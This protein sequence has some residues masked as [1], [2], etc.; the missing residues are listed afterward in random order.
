MA[1]EVGGMS[2]ERLCTVCNGRQM[3][4]VQGPNA[5]HPCEHC[6]GTGIEPAA[7][8]TDEGK[9]QIG[10]RQAG[11][12]SNGCVIWREYNSGGFYGASRDL[13]PAL[14][15]AIRYPLEEQRDAF[16]EVRLDLDRE[17]KALHEK[18]IHEV[19]LRAAAEERIRELEAI[20]FH[21]DG[22]MHIAT[23][24]IETLEDEVE[25]LREALRTILD[26]TRVG[27]SSY[28]IGVIAH[29]AL[30]TPPSSTEGTE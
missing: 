24:R 7:P 17:K 10:W 19:E 26:R 16:K 2:D 21:T 8:S 22:I 11:V 29:R 6:R 9:P 1:A 27:P 20:A 13:P 15:A 14:V 25:R 30:A 18:W 12:L 23:E 4:F 5:S 3:I 28:D